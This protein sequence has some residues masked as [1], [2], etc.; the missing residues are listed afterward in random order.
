MENIE[1]VET[2]GEMEVLSEMDML[3]DVATF[4]KSFVSIK[5]VVITLVITIFI[6]PKCINLLEVF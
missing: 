4:F 3:N 5:M 1:D 2:T 6:I